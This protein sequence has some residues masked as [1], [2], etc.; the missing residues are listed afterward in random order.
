M[1]IVIIG[2]GNVGRG[3]AQILRDKGAALKRQYGFEARII[4]VATRTRGTLYRAEGLDVAALLDGIE[5]YPDQPGLE[6]DWSAESLA[7]KSKA[8]VLVEISPTDLQTGQPA[9]DLC[10]AALISGKHVVLANK[11]PVAVAYDELQRLAASSGKLLRFEG[12]VM[13]G[14]PSLRL[15]MQA[16]AGCTIQRVRGILNGST[17]YMLTQME[18][19]KTYDEAQ[20]EALALGYLEADPSADV[21]GWDAAGKGI[22]LA[23]ALFGK[24]LTL[25]EMTVSGIRHV[26]LEDIQAARANGQRIKLIVEVTPERGSVTAMHLP[27]SHPLANVSGANNAITYTTDLMGDI[28]LIGAGAGRVQ[29]GFALLSDLL[30]IHEKGG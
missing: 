10:R 17:N 26:T 4:G 13:A 11:G 15:G 18:G 27:A 21:D 16:L 12:T 28:T 3:L 29:T 22:I 9:L 8:D 7:R 25:G 5:K 14:T 19:G 6:R 24:K 30:E 20:A 23:A 1:D 2:F